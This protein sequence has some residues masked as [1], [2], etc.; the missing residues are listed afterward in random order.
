[1]PLSV[2]FVLFRTTLLHWLHHLVGWLV[3][4]V[5]LRV[6]SKEAL[7]G[8]KIPG[9]GGRGRLYLTL[10]CHHQNDFSIKMGSDESQSNV[11]LMVRGKVTRQCSQT[12]T[13]EERGDSGRYGT[14]VLLLTSLTP[15]CAAGDRPHCATLHCPSEG[16]GG[17]S[18]HQRG[19]GAVQRGRQTSQGQPASSQLPLLLAWSFSHSHSAC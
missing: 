1:M 18:Q 5:L 7:V 11:S 15:I 14:K 10:C 4:L 19:Q 6:V 12:T 8:T 2:S 9:G 3:K 13:S 16:G 17:S